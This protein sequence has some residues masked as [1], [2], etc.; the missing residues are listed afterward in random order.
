MVLGVGECHSNFLSRGKRS[1]KQLFKQ[2]IR[3][4]S[5]QDQ[6]R[7]ALVAARIG[8]GAVA[9]MQG[10]SNSIANTFNGVGNQMTNAVA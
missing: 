7:F 8:L 1:M 10:L 9:A 6:S 5:G 2:F 4:E 3:E